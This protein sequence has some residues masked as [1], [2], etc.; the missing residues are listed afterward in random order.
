MYEYYIKG[1]TNPN[2]GC[3]FG[4]YLM[5]HLTQISDNV[6]NKQFSDYEFVLVTDGKFYL[7]D[8]EITNGK[9]IYVTPKDYEVIINYLQ[10]KRNKE[11]IVNGSTICKNPTDRFIIVGMEYDNSLSYRET[12]Q[13]FYK[14]LLKP[15]QVVFENF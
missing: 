4:T 13:Q 7:R 9:Q 6:V 14:E 15:C 1:V 2:P 5:P 11:F 8:N 12:V 10:K 3:H